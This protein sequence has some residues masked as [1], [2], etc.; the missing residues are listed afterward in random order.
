MDWSA[1]DYIEPEGYLMFIRSAWSASS[2]NSSLYSN[3]DL[4][5]QAMSIE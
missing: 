5:V 2:S 4:G 1:E 3:G